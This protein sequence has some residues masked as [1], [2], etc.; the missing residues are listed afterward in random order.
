LALAAKKNAINCNG[1]NW[2]KGLIKLKLGVTVLYR[3][4]F[5]SRTPAKVKITLLL[6]IFG[7]K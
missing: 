1:I 6:G 4:K 2:F 3:L 7:M 5:A